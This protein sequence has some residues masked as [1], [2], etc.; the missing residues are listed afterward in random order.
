MRGRLWSATCR[1]RLFVTFSAATRKTAAQQ[2]GTGQNA[3]SEFAFHDVAC[4]LIQ[5]VKG[6]SVRGGLSL[7]PERGRLTRLR[8][9]VLPVP[10]AAL[11]AV[12]R[13]ANPPRAQG[14]RASRLGSRR[15]SR[16]GCLR[17]SETATSPSHT[18]ARARVLTSS[19]HRPHFVPVT[20]RP[21]LRRA[22]PFVWSD[23]LSPLE[24]P[25]PARSG[26]RISNGISKQNE[27][28]EQ[29]RSCSLEK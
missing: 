11:P 25:S 9:S 13:V 26:P 28:R 7:K 16:Q 6:M 14:R 1:R 5:N 2:Q 17:Y 24:T 22:P 3:G 4:L 23:L 10:Q 29:D 21:D 15:N 19:G 20:S 12:S 8:G 27:K 18:A